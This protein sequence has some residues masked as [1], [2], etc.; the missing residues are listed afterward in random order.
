MR[1]IEAERVLPASVG[2]VWAIGTDPSTWADRFTI[3]IAGRL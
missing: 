3:R 1:N 2:A